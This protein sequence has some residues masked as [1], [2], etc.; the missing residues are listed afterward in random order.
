MQQQYEYHRLYIT[1]ADTGVKMYL[2]FDFTI[3]PS[4]TL[5]SGSV[6]SYEPESWA[7]VQ[8]KPIAF[9]PEKAFGT[10]LNNKNEFTKHVHGVYAD[11]LQALHHALSVEPIGA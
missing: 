8:K 7:I 10:I 2:V 11:E 9:I 6:V 4:N 5:P 1:D 3:V